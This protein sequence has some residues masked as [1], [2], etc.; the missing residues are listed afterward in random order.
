MA[1]WDFES[2]R[3]GI[4]RTGMIERQWCGSM[5]TGDQVSDTFTRGQSHDYP[6][7]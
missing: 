5:F 1:L 2:S 7:A 3:F 6:S 4:R